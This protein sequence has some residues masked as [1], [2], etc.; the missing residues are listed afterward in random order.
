MMKKQMKMLLT[1][2]LALVVTMGCAVPAFADSSVTYIDGAE[3]FVFEPG[4]EQSPTDLFPDFKGVM[5]GDTL[6]ENITIKVD[7]EQDSTLKI[8][9]RSLGSQEN[10]EEFLSQM[11]LTVEQVGKDT[12][13]EAPADQTAQL[14]DWVDLGYFG[15]GVD[16]TLK[17][18]LEVPIEMGNDFQDAIGYLDWQ[19][20]VEKIP[21]PEDEIVDEPEE[22][23]QPAPEEPQDDDQKTEDDENIIDSEDGP[24]TGDRANLELYVA[25]GVICMMLLFAAL[26][27]YKGKDN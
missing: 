15:S 17:V 22:P 20:K 21:L 18:T 8:Y 6:T 5:P 2:L 4:S 24:D 25:I 9:L 7:G 10:S 3:E 12:L 11:K 27:V 13:Y 26:F 1:L 14:T 16:V 19:F 23:V